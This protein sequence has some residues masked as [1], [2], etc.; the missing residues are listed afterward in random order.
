MIIDEI[1]MAVRL[2]RKVAKLTQ[3]QLAVLAGVGKTVIYD[4]E[5]AKTTIKLSTLISVLDTLNIK[6]TLQRPLHQGSIT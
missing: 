2:H 3:Q 5:K 1:A 6:L 4:I